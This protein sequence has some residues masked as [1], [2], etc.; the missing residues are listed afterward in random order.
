MVKYKACARHG[1]Y[2][3]ETGTATRCWCGRF[4]KTY[5]TIDELEADWEI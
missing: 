5:D 1:I 2:N 4:L 3:D